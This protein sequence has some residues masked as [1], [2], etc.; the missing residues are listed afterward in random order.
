MDTGGRIHPIEHKKGIIHAPHFS[1][2]S[3]RR[4]ATGLSV[5]IKGCNFVSTSSRKERVAAPDLL[6]DSGPTE[7]EVNYPIIKKLV[8][9]LIY[10]EQRLCRYFQT[11][12]IDVLTS[13]PIKQVLLKPKTSGRL[14]KWAIELGEHDISYHPRISIKGQALADLLF[15]IPGEIQWEMTDTTQ[16]IYQEEKTDK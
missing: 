15:E 4:D 14:E 6:R 5:Y 16:Q 3:T 8:L 2:P 9:A 1:L 13:C 10:E 7:A 12:Q 11:H